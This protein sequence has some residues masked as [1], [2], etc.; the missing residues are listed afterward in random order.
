MKSEPA[1]I[2]AAVES[3]ARQ[4]GDKTFVRTP[5]RTASFVEIEASAFRFARALRAA[6]IGHGD[7]VAIMLPNRIEFLVAWFGCARLG[8][9][10][11][12]IN[13]EFK[14]EILEYVL[15]SSRARALVCGPEQA[16]VA[17]S[18]RGSLPDLAH[19]VVVTEAAEGLPLR[20]RTWENF[21][22]AGGNI[23]LEPLESVVASDVAHIAFTSGTTGRSKGALLPHRRVIQTAVDMIDIRRIAEHDTLYTCL[24]LFH[25]NAKYLTVML[26]LLSGAEVALGRRFSASRF[27][28]DI[29]TFEATQFNYL[30]V[31]VAILNKQPPRSDDRD[32]PARLA[33]G[34][35][36]PRAAAI[37][38]EQRFGT[39]LLEGYGQTETGVPVS[40]TL[41]SR[42]PGACGRPLPGFEVAVVDDADVAMPTGEVG[43]IV[44]RPTRAHTTM[45]G[46]HE[47]PRETVQKI[48]NLWLHTGDLGRFDDDGFLWF[49]GRT[50]NVIRR[51]G[52]NI[53]ACEIEHIVDRHPDVL[54]CAAIAVPS[55]VTEDEVLL[56]AAARP[57]AELTVEALASY[58]E[59]A[60]PSFWLPRYVRLSR[61][62]LPRTATN[63]V[64]IGVLKA[65]GVA[66]A[67][68]RLVATE[69]AV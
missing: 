5:E 39:L 61:D 52:E 3:A 51:R 32:H 34:A 64:E 67:W 36:A 43:E 63:K 19:L 16:S 37:A 44:V 6:G 23:P 18:V 22:L 60:M 59:E 50:D 24:P 41:S 66:D 29:R 42:K 55:E 28:R 20:A 2:A 7:A 21:N 30:G 47:M 56:V 11:V 26:G 53:S 13:T 27:W 12:S 17:A 15:A 25:G 45:L 1:T 35:G 38:F 40:N 9:V 68:D 69:V 49:A 14:G 57:D 4:W 65:Q 31:M 58:C 10:E 46:Y 8:A 62:R 54:E 33:W 48:R